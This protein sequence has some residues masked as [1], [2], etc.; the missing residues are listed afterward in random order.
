MCLSALHRIERLTS[1]HT[2]VH[3]L[4][5]VLHFVCFTDNPLSTIVTDLNSL[6]S[7]VMLQL[8]PQRFQHHACWLQQACRLERRP[9]Q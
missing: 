4:A 3:L 1:L 6:M 2:K 5:M 9:Q 8:Q 7:L